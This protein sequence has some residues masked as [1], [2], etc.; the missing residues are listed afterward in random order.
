MAGARFLAAHPQSNGKVGVVGFVS[1]A[2]DQRPG[3][4]P[5]RHVKGAAPFYG[6]QLDLALVPQ[7]KGELLIHY[8]ELDTRINAGWRPMNRRSRDAGVQY[9]AHIYPES[10]TP[11]STTP[12][13]YDADAA[14]PGAHRR[15]FQTKLK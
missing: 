10:T 14:G 4:S 13:R 12:P 7:I 15:F 8:A 3:L 9:A 2:G 6:R 11:S 5:A 1:V